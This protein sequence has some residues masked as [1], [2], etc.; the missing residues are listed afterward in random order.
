MGSTATGTVLRYVCGLATGGA[1]R[2]LPDSDLLERFAGQGDADA[3]AELLRRHARLVWGV[4][5]HL[6]RGEQDAEDAFQATFLALANKAAAVRRETVAG[7]L[8]GTAYRC[9]LQLRRQDARRREREAKVVR[10]RQQAAPDSEVACR[11]LL[12]VLHEEVARLPAGLR[13]A[14]GLCGMD[15]LPVRDAAARLGRPEGTVSW[16]LTQARERLRGRLARRGIALPAVLGMLALVR[17]TRAAVR[18]ALLGATA[19]AAAALARTGAVPAGVVPAEVW[20]LMSEVNPSMF[21]SKGKVLAVCLVMASLAVGLGGLAL[22]PGPAPQARAGADEPDRAVRPAPGAKATAEKAFG[23]A[24][25]EA[26]TDKPIRGVAVWVRRL[27]NGKPTGEVKLVSDAAGRFHFDLP[28]DW[29]Q[30]RHAKVAVSVEAPPGYA[31]FPY[32]TL[33]GRPTEGGITLNALQTEKALGVPPYFDRILLFPTQPIRGR[34][35]DPDGKPAAGVAVVACSVHLKDKATPPHRLI[36]RM[37]TDANGRFEAD[38]MSPGPAVLYLLPD[39]Y[40][41]RYVKLTDPAGDLGDYKLERGVEVAGKLRD[42]KNQPL[43]GRWVRVGTPPGPDSDRELWTVG[44]GGFARWCRTG[45]DGTF[46]TAPLPDG[47]YQATAHGTNRSAHVAEEDGITDPSWDELAGRERVGEPLEVCIV[48]QKVSVRAGKAAPVV[49]RAVPHV[50]VEIRVA[51]RDG[52]PREAAFPY[53]YTFE[54]AEPW[55]YQGS[56]EWPTTHGGRL[57][58]RVPHGSSRLDCQAISHGAVCSFQPP[59][60]PKDDKLFARGQILALFGGLDADKRVDVLWVGE[61]DASLKLSAKDGS[62]LEGVE[63]DARH[64]AANPIGAAPM[65][66]G[67]YLLWHVQP[68]KAFSINVKAEGYQPVTREFTVPTGKPTRIEIVL[69]KA[70]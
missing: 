12:A 9:A 18:P 31:G 62:P 6:L 59:K 2:R 53:R 23:G 15:G 34:V 13:E 51:D 45:P 65:G 17:D 49:L 37:K 10:G 21:L 56:L 50:N 22:G 4:C 47:D 19:R 26:G 28:A 33:L 46:R 64:D 63:I 69:E 11:E 3:F 43:P 60:G 7:W 24:V 67:A 30:T 48:P 1:S 68:D 29:A 16:W 36:R 54:G 14:F 57:V 41:A 52:K 27:V 5:R 38:V 39:R 55:G 25:V 35:L 42:L 8:Q 70:K 58:I 32:R 44:I 61:A 40:A 66:G 20:N